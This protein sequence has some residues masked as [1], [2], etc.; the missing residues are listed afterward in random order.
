[1][2]TARILLATLLIGAPAHS[3][4]AQLRLPVVPLPVQPVQ[5]LTQ[6]LAQTGNDSLEPLS[7]LRSLQ[8]QRLLRANPGTL[9]AD[10]HGNIIIRDELLAYSPADQ[11][12]ETAQSHGFKI[13]R[14]QG[15]GELGLRLVVLQPPPMKIAKALEAS[16]VSWIPPAST[17]SI[18]C[19]PRADK[20]RRPARR[21]RS[22]RTQIP[23]LAPVLN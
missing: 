15:S 22:G 19:M 2:L 18:T 11:A 10:P 8:I 4:F 5:K 3:A 20:S 1:M 6:S 12:L 9:A 14:Q 16:C 7:S 17:T 13:L 21:C 23:I